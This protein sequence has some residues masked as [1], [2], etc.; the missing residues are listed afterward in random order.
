MN[1]AA[2]QGQLDQAALL[3]D[4]TPLDTPELAPT[5]SMLPDGEQPMAGTA[6]KPGVY[7]WDGL[8]FGDYVIGVIGEMPANLASLRVTDAS[9]NPLQNPVLGLDELSPRVDYFYF[10]FLAEGTPAA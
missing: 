8:A 9:G 5:L 7:D 1:E 4:C 2:A 6:T 3:A 10:Y